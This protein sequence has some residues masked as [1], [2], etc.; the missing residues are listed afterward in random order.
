MKKRGRRQL[1][2]VG[3]PPSWAT[4]RDNLLHWPLVWRTVWETRRAVWDEPDVRATLDGLRNTLAGAV[5]ALQREAQSI[6]YSAM[7]AQDLVTW[8]EGAVWVDH[9]I[10]S[11]IPREAI[12]DRAPGV[13]VPLAMETLLRAG[14]LVAIDGSQVDP[15][16]LALRTAARY[17]RGPSVWAEIQRRGANHKPGFHAALFAWFVRTTQEARAGEDLEWLGEISLK[18]LTKRVRRRATRRGEDVPSQI[19][20]TIQNRLGKQDPLETLAKSLEGGYDR[21]GGTVLYALT[22]G[23]RSTERKEMEIVFLD[24]PEGPDPDARTFHDV[25]PDP[26]PR[27]DDR[28]VTRDRLGEVFAAAEK[29][30]RVLRLI[31]SALEG[32]ETQAQIAERWGLTDRSVRYMIQHLRKRFPPD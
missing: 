16:G 24:A 22:R 6:D 9:L 1:V 26:L 15:R 2:T 19:F 5:E 27:A 17:L 4:L 8:L 25:V 7:P 30:D 31:V 13:R 14:L 29:D 18:Y 28:A 3:R 11:L 10:R 23:K 20:L 32:D 21:I 12:A